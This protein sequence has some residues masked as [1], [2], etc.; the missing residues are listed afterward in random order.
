MSL[1]TASPNSSSS[2][3]ALLGSLTMTGGEG[4]GLRAGLSLCRLFLKK[5]GLWFAGR[6]NLRTRL[7][8]GLPELPGKSSSGS[9]TLFSS[10]T[11][12]CLGGGRVTTTAVCSVLETKLSST[13]PPAMLSGTINPLSAKFSKSPTGFTFGM[14]LEVKEFKRFFGMGRFPLRVRR[15]SGRTLGRER[16]RPPDDNPEFVLIL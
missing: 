5:S 12:R 13:S 11:T 8:N 3:A 10:W 6:N 1:I 14:N 15:S 2:L 7:R 9:G 4:L 16:I